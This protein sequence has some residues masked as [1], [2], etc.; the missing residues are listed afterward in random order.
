MKSTRLRALTGEEKIISNSQA[1]RKGNHQQH[2]SVYRRVNFLIG[3]V[4]QTPGIVAA[5]VPRP[6]ARNCR[7]EGADF[8]RGGLTIA[9]SAQ[10]ARFPAGLRCAKRGNR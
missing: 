4:Y 7:G 6:V 3:L 8:I 10:F 2:K 9:F 1:A 5:R